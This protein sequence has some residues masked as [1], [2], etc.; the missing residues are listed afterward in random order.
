MAQQV[1][2]SNLFAAEDWKV[3]YSAFRKI[4]LTSY[5][6]DDIRT[7]IINHLQTTYPDSFNDW[8]NNQEFIFILDTLSFLGQNLA[9]RMDL[10]T[11]DNFIDTAERRESVLRLAQMLSYSPKR[12]YCARGLVK[13]TQI[14]TNRDVRDSNGKTISGK[15]IKWNDPL[16]P[17]WYEQFILALNANLVESNTF[18]NPVKR[19]LSGQTQTHLYRL[20]SI[21][22]SSVV[23]P[24]SASVNGQ[25]M[26]FEIVN[27]DFDNAGVIFER[28]PEPMGNMYILYRNDGNGFA[29]PD[30]GFFMYFKQGTLKFDDFSYTT[31]IEN[32]TTDINT[33]NINETDVWVQEVN[34]EGVVV[35]KWTKVPSTQN[36]MYNSV[37]QQIKSIFSVVT[38]DKDMVSIR[39]PDSSTGTVPRGI[40]RI[41]YRVSNG[42]GYTIKTSDIQNKSI[43][44]TTRSQNQ[45]ESEKSS[46]EIKFSLEYQIQNAQPQET[47]EQ[48]RVRAPQTYY[49]NNRMISGEDYNIG[50][51]RQGNL[52]KKS[53]A[54]NRTYSG[55]SRFIDINDPTSTYQN[56]SVFGDD[57]I[58][59]KDTTS[60]RMRTSENLPSAKPNFAI[61]NQRIRTLLE[62]P[63]MRQLYQEQAGYKITIQNTIVTWVPNLNR[64]P[65]G[66]I[67][68]IVGSLPTDP[69]GA[70]QNVVT[71]GMLMRFEDPGIGNGHIWVTITQYDYRDR[72]CVLSEAVPGGWILTHYYPALKNL[73]ST[74]EMNKISAEMNKRTDFGLY[75]NHLKS[76]WLVTSDARRFDFVNEFKLTGTPANDC[77][78]KVEFNGARW[79]FIARGADYVFSNANTVRFYTPASRKTIDVR[80]GVARRDEITILRSNPSPVTGLAYTKDYKLLIDDRVTQEDGRLDAT[81]VVVTSADVDV[82]NV[83]SDP[84]LF[85]N[86]VSGNSNVEVF[87]KGNENNETEVV[88][89]S[90]SEPFFVYWPGYISTAP[91]NVNRKSGIYSSSLDVNKPIG[92]V[93]YHYER[94][95]FIRYKVSM[96]GVDPNTYLG[97]LPLDD[98]I[99]AYLAGKGM[100]IVY[101]YSMK[102]GRT[103]L[104]YQWKHFAPETHRIDPAVTNI[105]DIYVITSE[106]F[107]EVD[108]WARSRT[109][110][111]MPKPPTTVT[112]RESFRDLDKIKATSDSIIWNSGTFV[113]LF[114]DHAKPET[115]AIF[116]LV[117]AT[118]SRYSDD[119]L[120]QMVIQHINEFFNIDNW[121]FGD[122]F[123]FT[124]LVTYIHQK[125]STDIASLVIVPKSPGARFGNLFQVSCESNELFISTAKVDDVEVVNSLTPNNMKVGR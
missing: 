124:E 2:Q 84:D 73:F 58:L 7:S 16:N 118:G 119:E 113:P 87:F 46:I 22:M 14:S 27:P 11:R 62:Y 101:N 53:K 68:E 60:A 31:P 57:G 43:A 55:H 76:Q 48:I 98:T 37:S 20:S 91:E 95:L 24:F 50:P 120:R 114:G 59:Y 115:Q 122:T 1:R 70:T 54:I 25:T 90:T 108:V 45:T 21:P 26:N 79:D 83:P 93:F 61:I 64:V 71:A 51:L 40:Y 99:H 38:K 107:N 13:V 41:W 56:V 123:Y 10:N 5:S 74:D 125:L 85:V 105:H 88:G 63:S 94:G 44:I 17:D 102:K 65:A 33:A 3:V 6:Y 100:E 32:R 9:F 92:T 69:Y 42:L 80:S 67:G 86:L 121:D 117:R 116:R 96:K 4:N 23:Y 82:N 15:V 47:V 89:L 66:A 35:E 52:V 36:I 39:Y 111:E 34:T 112:L 29:S 109:Q 106:Y 77:F 103:N 12:N 72:S 75:Y 97:T 49:T 78:I 81:R 30:T 18:G 8:I 28:H 104:L 19:M 110:N